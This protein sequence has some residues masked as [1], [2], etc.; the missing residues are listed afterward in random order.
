MGTKLQKIY[1]TYS[2][3]LKKQGLWQAHYQILTIIFLKKFI[4]LNINTDTM[5]KNMKLVELHTNCAAVFLNTQTLNIQQNKM[6]ML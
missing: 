4:K 2:N 1:I 6:F 5:I 3:S